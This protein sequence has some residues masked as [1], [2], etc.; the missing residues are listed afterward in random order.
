MINSKDARSQGQINSGTLS[1]HETTLERLVAIGQVVRMVCVGPEV[2]FPARKMPFPT[3]RLTNP[4]AANV[5]ERGRTKPQIQRSTQ[6]DTLWMGSGCLFQLNQAINSCQHRARSD[7]MITSK[8]RSKK[9][10]LLHSAGLGNAPPLFPKGA[11]HPDFS[12]P[13]CKTTSQAGSFRDSTSGSG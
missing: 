10:L 6:F 4:F 11:L 9:R 2:L 13:Q 12:L 8:L 7:Y 5:L 1:V 3:K